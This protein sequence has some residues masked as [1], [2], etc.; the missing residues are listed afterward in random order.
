MVF[1]FLKKKSQASGNGIANIFKKI[2]LNQNVTFNKSLSHDFDNEPRFS[3]HVDSIDGS[4]DS[5]DSTVMGGSAPFSDMNISP[6]SSDPATKNTAFDRKS[7]EQDTVS[8]DIFAQVQNVAATQKKTQN[9]S[10]QSQVRYAYGPTKEQQA[11][12]NYY[13]YPR[14]ET[15]LNEDG[16]DTGHLYIA[17]GEPLKPIRKKPL[18]EM[19]PVQTDIFNE[20]STQQ[21]DNSRLEQTS[22]DHSDGQVFSTLNVNKDIL[23]NNSSDEYPS[24]ASAEDDINGKTVSADKSIFVNVKKIDNAGTADEDNKA[25]SD[26]GS[27]DSRHGCNDMSRVGNEGSEKRA[28]QDASVSVFVLFVLFIRQFIASFFNYTNL[29]A[30]VPKKGLQVLGPSAPAFM[31]IP[32]FVVGFLCCGLATLLQSA[33]GSSHFVATITTLLYLLLTGS[34]A[35][36]GIG[37]FCTALT[38]RKT[39]SYG[40]AVIV[41]VCVALFNSA[42]DFY[43]SHAVMNMEF[44]LGFGAV[45]MLS[46]LSGA[47]LNFGGADD[48]VSS[49]GTMGIKGLVL[50][51]IFSVGITYLFLDWAIASSLVGISILSRIVIGQIMIAK[52]LKSSSETVLAAQ[53]IT[54]C[55]LMVDIIFASGHIPFANMALFG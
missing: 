53:F 3:Q 2:Q 14:D 41:L 34:A 37:K 5:H 32:F 46:A 8:Q 13:T 40:K 4:F 7:F 22:H 28:S 17:P 35:F 29:C 27:T 31:P 16:R 36:S 21:S 18:E 44:C 15:Y 42:F 25:G 47:S 26:I 6:S 52:R 33:T 11:R 30:V 20:N 43:L 23:S 9:S 55:V 50:S 54:L 39:D 10:E 51:F 48:P 1:G 49:F 38:L 24:T 45:V 12:R 19:Q